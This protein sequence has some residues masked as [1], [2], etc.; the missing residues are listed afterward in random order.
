MKIADGIFAPGKVM[1]FGEYAVL[2]GQPALVAAVARGVRCTIHPSTE[3]IIDGGRHGRAIR[4]AEGWRGDALPFAQTLVD[5][6]PDA[7][8]ATYQLDSDALS[9]DGTKL[10]LGSS[11]ASTVALARALTPDASPR[12]IYTHAQAAHRAVQ[13]TGS[14]ADIAASAWGGVIGYRWIEGHGEV[15]PIARTH[16]QRTHLHMVWAGQPASTTALVG[17]VK[18][19]AKSAPDEHAEIMRRIGVAAEQGMRAWTQG[20]DLRPAARATTVC[21]VDLGRLSGAPIVTACHRELSDVVDGSGVVVKPTGAGG[22]DL[23]WLV[24][25][26][27]PSEALALDRLRAA[28]HACFALPIWPNDSPPTS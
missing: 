3:L 15:E 5:A 12:D 6:L 24:G 2:H 21:L 7:A 27:A 23:A 18:A 19:W 9:V 26:T 20:S 25:P 28:G 16:Q 13:G 22:G 8:I 17:R 14:G 1:L 10:G 4:G 11:A